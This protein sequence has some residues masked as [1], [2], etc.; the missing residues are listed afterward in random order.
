MCLPTRFLIISL[1]HHR[2]V[3]YLCGTSFSVEEEEMEDVTATEE[4]GVERSLH[5]SLCKIGCQCS[6][7]R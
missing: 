5:G 1:H 4:E 6:Q 3:W 7:A 2:L